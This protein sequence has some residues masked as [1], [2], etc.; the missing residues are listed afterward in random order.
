[1][2][3]FFFGDEDQHH[4]QKMTTL[5]EATRAVNCY[6]EIMTFRKCVACFKE[7]AAACPDFNEDF[8]G[9]YIAVIEQRVYMYLRGSL[10]VHVVRFL[11]AFAEHLKISMLKHKGIPSP[12]EMRQIKVTL[13]TEVVAQRLQKN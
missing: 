12:S 5:E 9:L 6:R 7:F 3:F 13:L 2:G 10:V 4:K 8:V 11:D 1:M